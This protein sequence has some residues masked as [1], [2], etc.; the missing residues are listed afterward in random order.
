MPALRSGLGLRRCAKS[1]CCDKAALTGTPNVVVAKFDC[2][3][4]KAVSLSLLQGRSDYKKGKGFY[5]IT[6]LPTS[7]VNDYL[8]WKA[9]TTPGKCAEECSVTLP[10]YPTFD[11]LPFI[12]V[13]EGRHPD[14]TGHVDEGPC[15][16]KVMKR[17]TK[18][19]HAAASLIRLA[20]SEHCMDLK[21]AWNR[22]ISKYVAAVR[23]AGGTIFCKPEGKTCD[24]EYQRILTELSG[25]SWNT[26]TA[27]IKCNLDAAQDYRDDNQWHTFSDE[28]MK[29]IPD[30]KCKEV[31]YVIDPATQK[32]IGTH[33]TEEVLDKAGCKT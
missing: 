3:A 5:G 15:K 33:T 32:D 13:E 14:G 23:L 16:G 21:L 17:Y 25:A 9:V 6:S 4:V 8:N 27:N 7:Q 20:E 12:S 10:T 26:R 28:N 31:D 29:K 24:E 11:L 1:K 18:I 2:Y 30:E 19:T 22:S